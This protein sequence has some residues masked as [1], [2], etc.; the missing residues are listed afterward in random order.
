MK[1]N[2][3]LSLMDKWGFIRDLSLEDAIKQI[4]PYDLESLL[5]EWSILQ[6][7]SFKTEDICTTSPEIPMVPV[8]STADLSPDLIANI[9]LYSDNQ[10]IPDPID[11]ALDKTI[12]PFEN[13]AGFLLYLKEGMAS[14]EKIRPLLRENLVEL[15]SYRSIESQFSSDLRDQL[16]KDW[17]DY[18]T[19]QFL[20]NKIKYKLYLNDNV[21]AF[22]VGDANIIPFERFAD[23]GGKVIDETDESISV[24]TIIPSDLRDIDS[25]RIRQ[26]VYMMRNITANRIAHRINQRLLMAE[27]VSGAIASNEFISYEF[28]KRKH[29]NSPSSSML[30]HIHKIPILGKINLEKFIE[31]RSDE[32]PSFVSFRKEW[33][34]GRGLFEEEVSSDIWIRNINIELNK[35]KAEMDKS[36]KKIIGNIIEGFA[37]AGFGVAAGVFSGSL[38]WPAT[39][40]AIPELIKDIKNATVAY[41]EMKRSFTTSSP[42]F[43]LNVLDRTNNIRTAIPS[44]LP[45]RMPFDLTKT[46]LR[47]K[48]APLKR[49]TTPDGKYEY[50][51]V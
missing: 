44:D 15:V 5:K 2:K 28:V 4:D 1:G 24:A 40:V 51:T 25:E 49:E 8:T 27:L 50:L 18:K 32:L 33:N 43:L 20:N 29:S 42:F 36:K 17:S 3:Y 14:I 38:L 11:I 16:M 13:I 12:N 26:W 31:F 7:E 39:I 23:I 21:L 10:I 34:E 46:F 6:E 9:A 22:Q 19:I 41:N 35:C 47:L 30:D 48:G 37:W 45:E